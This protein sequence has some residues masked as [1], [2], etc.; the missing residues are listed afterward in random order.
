VTG[1]GQFKPP[2]SAAFGV[3]LAFVL[4]LIK[5]LQKPKPRT[6]AGNIGDDAS[7]NKIT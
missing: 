7:G 6:P 4:Q 5:D 3:R 2:A 1:H